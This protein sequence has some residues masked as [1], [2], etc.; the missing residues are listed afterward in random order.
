MAEPLLASRLAH[1]LPILVAE[2]ILD[3]ATADRLRARY[4]DG[5]AERS[6]SRVA[7]LL[8]ALGAA[9]L[10]GGLI[11]LVGHNWDTL[12]LAA[13]TACALLP[14][15]L[16][17]VLAGWVLARER[18]VAWR[19]GAGTFWPLAAAASLGLIDQLYQMPGG[20][21]HLRVRA[22]L[23][24]LPA[25]YLLRSVSAAVLYLTGAA[26][27]SL[28][29]HH[30][31]DSELRYWL[32]LAAI[33]PFLVHRVRA[34]AAAPGTTLLGWWLAATFCFTVPFTVRHTFWW[35]WSTVFAA[36]FAA[37]VLFDRVWSPG[38]H[39]LARRP[40]R[41]LGTL[42][43]AGLTL[44]LG[45]DGVWSELRDVRRPLA[46]LFA[47]PNADLVLLLAAAAAF[48]AL[49]WWR[50]RRA[51]SG[52]RVI[53]LAPLA[54]LGAHLTADPGGENM[55]PSLMV[56]GFVLALGATHMAIGYR[57]SSARDANFG[58]VLLL[59]LLVVRFFDSD[60]AMVHRALAFLTLG[61]GVLATNWA[62]SRRRRSLA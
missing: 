55:A 20:W 42:G 1:D 26:V 56:N 41:T 19:E 31:F 34:H 36:L 14:L 58:M 9:L 25:V 8:G 30:A 53:A 50:V 13:R 60:I 43:V 2:G 48:V 4:R 16:A 12:S 37:F 54:V 29:G 27:W 24:A 40:F 5:A 17:L 44:T 59:G 33:A 22:L 3:G 28:A 6:S 46:G 57:H 49:L 10:G 18:G 38:E 47:E 51:T 45:A 23:M 62:L 32:L 39:T 11:L 15:S 21:E 7:M 52:E 35:S 61:A